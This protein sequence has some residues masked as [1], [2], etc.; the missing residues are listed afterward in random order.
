MRK[1]SMKFPR[2]LLLFSAPLLFLTRVLTAQKVEVK[3]IKLTQ[4]AD[5]ITVYL[6]PINKGQLAFWQAPKNDVG[7]DGGSHNQWKWDQNPKTVRFYDDIGLRDVGGAGHNITFENSEEM[8]LLLKGVAS[9]PANLK[10]GDSGKG[11]KHDKHSHGIQGDLD[12]KCTGTEIQN[13]ILK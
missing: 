9:F 12:W 8:V 11:E 5:S 6:Y 7:S 4:G 1:H 10:S 3:V 13:M 2:R